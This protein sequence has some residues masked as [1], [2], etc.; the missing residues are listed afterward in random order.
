[1]KR[2]LV[3]G[4]VKRIGL[5]ISRRLAAAGWH[6][7]AHYNRS[8]TE[9][10]ELCDWGKSAGLNVDCVRADLSKADETSNLLPTII[11]RFGP[12][13]CLIN[14][15]SQFELDT[16]ETVNA[17]SFQSHF[18]VNLFAPM[19][20]SK[21]FFENL[22]SDDDDPIIINILDQKVDNLNP[23]FLSYTLSK[24]A[25]HSLTKILANKWAGNV[26]VC[27]IAPGLALISGK[28]TQE[29]FERAWR[30]TPT[31][32]STTPDEIANAV[33]FLQNT[34]GVTGDTI[35]LDGG[36]RL[37][38]RARDVAFDDPSA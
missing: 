1:M 16:I 33:V 11:K 31:G 12:L 7:I 24:S 9:A 21:V 17:E 19:I 30:A 10:F 25:L 5:S 34:K 28:Q 36:E 3:T 37:L 29:S 22:D 13:S 38:R 18:K 26:R 20:L 6:V 23:D 8:E 2:V 15:A 35:F 27:A 14:N 4:G 32:R